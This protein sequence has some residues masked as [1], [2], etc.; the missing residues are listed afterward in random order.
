MCLTGVYTHRL[1]WLVPYLV[2]LATGA[3]ESPLL[4]RRRVSMGVVAL[5][6]LAL[7]W[8]AFFSVVA[9]PVVAVL[10]RHQRDHA[11]LVQTCR[12]A[13]GTGNVRVYLDAWQ[14]YYAGRQLGW[15]QYHNSGS[16]R[17][18]VLD[19]LS[20]R[21]TFLR[22]MDYYVANAGTV[23]DRMSNT[24]QRAGFAPQAEVHVG[25]GKTTARWQKMASRMAVGYGPYAIWRRQ[26]GG[27][28][29]D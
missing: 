27:K 28:G 17:E 9:R 26:D 3:V 24:L 2:V 8:G 20:G 11:A 10:A 25:P 14:V 12:E 22:R 19:L 15:R 4:A 23:T 6:A 5:V 16:A 13:I 7:V 1:N 21:I 18:T 29:A